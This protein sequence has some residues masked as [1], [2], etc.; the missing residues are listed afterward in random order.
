MPEGPGSATHGGVGR[1][2]SPQSE[3]RP[4]RRRGAARLGR[5]PRSTGENGP[6]IWAEGTLGR[7]REEMISAKLGTGQ[8]EERGRRFSDRLSRKEAG[9]RDTPESGVENGKGR[10]A[11]WTKEATATCRQHFLG[12]L[13]FLLHGENGA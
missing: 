7:G 12:A 2:G 8:D 13:D 3:V 10:A 11:W 1:Q 5:R 9:I 6:G 4:A